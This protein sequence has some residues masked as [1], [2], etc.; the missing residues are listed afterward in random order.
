MTG[1]EQ[2]VLKIDRYNKLRNIM[3]NLELAEAKSRMV[4]EDANQRI[5]QLEE[6]LHAIGSF[7]GEYAPFNSAMAKIQKIAQEGLE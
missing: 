1:T 5:E 7:S 4:L 2:V 6:I 3:D